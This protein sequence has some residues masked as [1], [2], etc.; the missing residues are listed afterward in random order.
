M[1]HGIIAFVSYVMWCGA[2]QMVWFDAAWC[3]VMSCGMAW[4]GKIQCGH[5]WFDVVCHRVVLCGVVSSSVVSYGMIWC[6]AKW[7]T[8]HYDAVQV[9]WCGMMLNNALQCTFLRA[10]LRCC[11]HLV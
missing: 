5:L 10:I 8:V 11:Q 7:C 1:R 6:V 9:M 3:D 2:V 4:C